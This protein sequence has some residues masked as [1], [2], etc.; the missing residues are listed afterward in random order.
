MFYLCTCFSLKFVYFSHY[1]ASWQWLVQREMIWYK[2][3]VL[4][5]WIE[6]SSFIFSLSLLFSQPSTWVTCSSLLRHP[7]AGA[8]VYQTCWTLPSLWD[9]NYRTL[10]MSRSWR[11]CRR[12]VSHLERSHCNSCAVFTFCTVFLFRRPQVGVVFQHYVNA[13]FLTSSFW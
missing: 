3:W 6:D 9:S 10:L 8:S 4:R 11:A 1:C 2:R 12:R 13:T 7:W 5:S